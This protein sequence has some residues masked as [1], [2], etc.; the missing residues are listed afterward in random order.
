M[1]EEG[2]FCYRWINKLTFCNLLRYNGRNNTDSRTHAFNLFLPALI[3]RYGSQSLVGLAFCPGC[4]EGGRWRP[5]HMGTPGSLQ[6]PCLC[7]G[8]SCLLCS[9]CPNSKN[10]TLT[11]LVYAFILFLGT[12]VCCIMFHEGMET[13]LKKVSRSNSSLINVVV[14]IIFIF[15][16]NSSCNWYLFLQCCETQSSSVDWLGS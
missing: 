9:C 12:I 11:R 5:S 2:R 15:C 16:K 3:L 7:G 14:L 8:A 6:V 4:Q 13:Q 1:S 10:S